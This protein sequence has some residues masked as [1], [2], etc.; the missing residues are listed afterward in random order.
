MA[1]HHG[2]LRRAQEE[3]DQAFATGKLT[4]PVPTSVECLA[5]P[6]VH[7]CMR[8]IM[9]INATSSPRWRA[10]LDRSLPL[11]DRIVPPGVAIATS[12]YTICTS[13]KI[14][15]K[16]A[17]EFLPV[18]W[19]EATEEQLRI[20]DRYDSHWGFGYRKCPGRFIGTML[21]SKSI[22]MV[23]KPK[24]LALIYWRVL[25]SSRYFATLTLSR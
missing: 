1:A 6:Y 23:S 17:D 18:R 24:P 21:M 20:W 7:A 10:S 25:T 2:P 9:R 5:L 8:E 11:G 22:V 16:D 14:W 13:P 12:P 4:G 19:L 15:G 3:I